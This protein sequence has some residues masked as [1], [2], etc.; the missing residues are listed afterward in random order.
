[1][2]DIRADDPALDRDDRLPWLEAVED[3]QEGGGPSA[4][5]LIVAVLI[6]LA[7]IGALVGGAFWLANRAG[8]NESASGAPEVIKAQPGDYKTKPD[9]PGGMNVSGEGDSAFAASAGADPKGQINTNAVPETPVTQTR[10][11]PAAQAGDQGLIKAPPPT[12]APAA[13]A[14]KPAA[15]AAAAPAAS[16]GAT[17]QLGAFP[18]S[19][20]AERSWKAM[21]GRFGYLAPLNHS[22]V[23]AQ[24]GGKTWYRLRASGPDASSVCGRLRVAGENCFRVD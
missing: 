10:G 7:A 3:D 13:P 19:A 16:G 14:A 22:V 5:K 9:N 20:E 23:S 1:M 4:L 6:G 15:P 2:T 11:Q 17:V 18:S 24:V 12:N 21:S 8:G